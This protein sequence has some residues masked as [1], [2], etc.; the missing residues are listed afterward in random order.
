MLQC[1][2]QEMGLQMRK[3]E[4]SS[5]REVRACQRWRRLRF[6]QDRTVLLGAKTRVK[7]R[8]H[9]ARTK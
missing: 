9:S 8:E 7:T 6:L 3:S 4:K 5:S 2:T 1:E